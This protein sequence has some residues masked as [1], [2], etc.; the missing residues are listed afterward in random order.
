[1]L[2]LGV[3][4]AK[5]FSVRCPWSGQKLAED[6]RE[7]LIGREDL[8]FPSYIDSPEKSKG[9][10][11]RITNYREKEEKTHCITLRAGQYSAGEVCEV[12]REHLC[13]GDKDERA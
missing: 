5:C 12:L 11:I 4:E 1:M 13:G 9:H 2:N 7:F 10:Q 6:L 8:L 3:K